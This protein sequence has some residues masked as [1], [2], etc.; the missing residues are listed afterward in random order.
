MKIIDNIIYIQ[1]NKAINFYKDENDCLYISEKD[2][3]NIF[4]CNNEKII[5]SDLI[6]IEMLL[7]RNPY[8]LQAKAI[9]IAPIVAI[10][11]ED[12]NLQRVSGILSIPTTP[13]KVKKIPIIISI[14]IMI[15][16]IPII[17]P[18]LYI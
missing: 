16:H 13:A 2:I 17:I 15:S 3:P 6:P 11:V 12:C 7:L 14:S 8:I 9:G 1:N 10:L 5:I 4:L 18:P